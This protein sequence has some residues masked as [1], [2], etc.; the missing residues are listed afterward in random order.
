MFAL[1]TKVMCWSNYLLHI[2][3]I[4]FEMFLLFLPFLDKILKK[5]QAYFVTMRLSMIKSV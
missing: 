5:I 1:L 2:F 3:I 4:K